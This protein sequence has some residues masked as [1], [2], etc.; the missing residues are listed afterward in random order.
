MKNSE[1]KNLV[2]LELC[3]PSPYEGNRMIPEDEGEQVMARYMEDRACTDA[4]RNW[5]YVFGPIKNE[6][7]R[8]KMIDLFDYIDNND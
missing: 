1:M 8:H 6:D 2:M 3:S 5:N 4:K 7:F